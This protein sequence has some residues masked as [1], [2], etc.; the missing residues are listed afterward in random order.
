MYTKVFFNILQLCVLESKLVVL[1]FLVYTG[2][3]ILPSSD[4][5]SSKI[6]PVRKQVSHFQHCVQLVE[7]HSYDLQIISFN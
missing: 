6:Y 1:N 4:L 7:I 2:F 3:R 5:Q